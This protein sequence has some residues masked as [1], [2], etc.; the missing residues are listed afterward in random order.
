VNA[1]PTDFRGLID[2]LARSRVD[3]IVVGGVAATIHGA[4]RATLD[5]D[6]VY[7][8]AAD[9]VERLVRALAPLSPYLRGAPA[10]LPF[11]FDADTVRRGLNFT[12]DTS[13]G[14]LDLLGEITGGGSYDAL[15]PNTE[16]IDLF[17][18]RC[19]AVTLDALIRLKRAA[20]RPKD[21][22]ALAELEALHERIMRG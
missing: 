4:A 11:S 14:A 18:H 9:N 13:L 2:V 20:G 5:L 6:L 16:E 21:N 10:G 12:L 1:R 8:R 19:R 22:E 3:F 7:S 15:L 17:G